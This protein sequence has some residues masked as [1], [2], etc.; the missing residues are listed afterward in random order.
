MDFY[1]H[2]QRHLRSDHGTKTAAHGSNA[3]QRHT[4]FGREHFGGK[5][6]HGIKCH[7]DGE[8]ATQE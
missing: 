4:Q 7:C 1:T 8:L 5:H 2:Q 6:V 3:E